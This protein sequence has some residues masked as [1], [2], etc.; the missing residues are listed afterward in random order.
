MNDVQK[1]GRVSNFMR[2]NK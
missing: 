2:Y 1:P